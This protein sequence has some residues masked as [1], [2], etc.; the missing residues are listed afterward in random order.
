MNF[1]DT[2]QFAL[3]IILFI[4]FAVFVRVQKHHER[5]LSDIIEDSTKLHINTAKS[6]RHI[7]NSLHSI[8]NS[9]KKEMERKLNEVL[10]KRK[11]RK[12][13]RTNKYSNPKKTDKILF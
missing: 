13:K 12:E 6:H 5:C 3:L 4:G 2:L 10:Q 8:K 7:I 1:I 9:H 11:E